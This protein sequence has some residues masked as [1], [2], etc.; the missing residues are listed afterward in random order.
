MYLQFDEETEFVNEILSILSGTYNIATITGGLYNPSVNGKVE[1][2][3]RTLKE[4]MGKYTIYK[5]GN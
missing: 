4:L 1:R 2:V 5:N 3:N